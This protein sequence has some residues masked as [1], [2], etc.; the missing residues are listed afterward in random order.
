M[1]LTA[2]LFTGWGTR[3]PKGPSS[4]SPRRNSSCRGKAPRRSTRSWR[5]RKDTPAPRLRQALPRSSFSTI[6]WICLYPWTPSSPPWGWA[7]KVGVMS[8]R[9]PW[10]TLQDLFPARSSPSS[11]APDHKML[12]LPSHP[13]RGALIGD[14]LDRHLPKGTSICHGLF[15]Q[16]ENLTS[17]S[18]TGRPY[19]SPPAF[20]RRRG[21]R[22]T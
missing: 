19:N 4:I 7:S 11:T 17:A 14:G 16:V 12:A 22:C 20:N 13:D 5:G 1:G 8:L 21:T 15:R 9:G 6:I 18:S 2:P 10:R 3:S